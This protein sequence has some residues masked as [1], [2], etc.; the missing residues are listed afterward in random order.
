VLAHE[1]DLKR[2]QVSFSVSSSEEVANDT[3]VALLYVQH[4]GGQAD[5]LA[6]AV[7]QTIRWGLSQTQGRPEI[8]TQTLDY[9]TDP[10]YNKGK[11]TGWRVRQSLRLESKDTSSLSELIGDLQSRLKVQ[12]IN[13]EISTEQQEAAQERLITESLTKFEARARQIAGDLKRP[14]YQLIQLNLNTGHYNPQPRMRSY[15]MAESMDVEPPQI[16]AG[17]GTLTVTANGTIELEI[18]N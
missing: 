17:T 2:N 3:L 11:I 15:A 14:G 12:S 10:I 9:R 18:S 5:K 13:Y 1:E 4:E 6:D 7:N 8:K 16:K